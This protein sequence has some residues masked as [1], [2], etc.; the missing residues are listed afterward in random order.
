MYT[1]YQPVASHGD[2]IYE[3]VCLDMGTDL[4]PSRP[5]FFVGGRYSKIPPSGEEVDASIIF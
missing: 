2:P 1:K 3:R 5:L 4:G